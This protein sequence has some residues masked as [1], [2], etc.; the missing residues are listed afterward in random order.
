VALLIDGITSKISLIFIKINTKKN[1]FYWYKNL[2]YTNLGNTNN[3]QIK[4]FSFH[5]FSP[6][7]SAGKVSRKL[8]RLTQKRCPAD[9]AD[10][11]R[12]GVMQIAQID[13]EKVS[14]RLRRW[15][16]EKVSCRLHRWTQKRCPADCADGRRKKTQ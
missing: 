4:N 2:I 1:A 10:E 7:T 6:L 5:H 3:K 13:A 11:R 15:D 9:C 14:C 16:A 12:K 8:R